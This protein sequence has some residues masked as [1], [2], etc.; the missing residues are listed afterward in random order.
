MRRTESRGLMT[1]GPSAVPASLIQ[2]GRRVVISLTAAG[3]GGQVF[4]HVPSTPGVRQSPGCASRS[5]RAGRPAHEKRRQPCRTGGYRFRVRS[6]MNWLT[7]ARAAGR[8]ARLT[9]P[10]V[11]APG[12]GPTAG[13][14]YL[15]A[16]L[17]NQ[18]PAQVWSTTWTGIGAWQLT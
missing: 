9:G 6:W 15:G 16:A 3:R 8:Y 7:G 18:G 11:L 1:A 13:G 10:A 17:R 2:A 5:R 12:L 4:G 14:C